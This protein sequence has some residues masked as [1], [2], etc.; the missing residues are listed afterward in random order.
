MAQ[1]VQR[2][3]ALEVIHVLGKLGPG[4]H[5]AHVAPEHVEQLGQL[6]DGVAAHEGAEGRAARVAGDGPAVRLMHVHAHRAELV[7]VEQ[8]AVASHALLLE[9]DRAGGGELGADDRHEHDGRGQHDEHG[10]P[11]HVHEALEERKAQVVEHDALHVDERHAAL[12]ADRGPAGEELV[13]CRQD[14]EFDAAALAGDEDGV[15]QVLFL[16]IDGDDDLV[17]QGGVEDVVDVGVRS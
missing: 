7:H 12:D 2:H 13:V 14:R 16:G 15:E 6:V 5:K 3:A 17:R 1:H 11:H 10:R 9:K 4:S 8:L